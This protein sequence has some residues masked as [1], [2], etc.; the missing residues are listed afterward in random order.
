[1][2]I[3]SSTNPLK[4]LMI[5]DSRGD[6]VLIR[7]S[8]DKAMPNAYVVD[9]A[10]TLS[11]ALNM[12]EGNEYDVALLDR[13]LPD[14]DGFSGLH[15]I[16]NMSPR[17][18]II[19]LTG[20]QDETTAFEAIEQGAQDYLFKDRL[21]GHVIKRSLQFS[22]LRK[23]FEG[24]LL[25]RA[26]FDPLT[27]LANRMLFDSRLDM[28]LARMRRQ[29]TILCVMFI[30]LD[31]FKRVN[32]NHGHLVGDR[33]LQL[34]GER[35]QSALRKT[36]TV[37]RFGGDEF[38]L[39]LESNHDDPDG[40]L[41]ANKIISLFEKPFHV[42]ERVFRVSISIGI[43]TCSYESIKSR[44]ILL[45]EADSAMYAAKHSVGSSYQL[46]RP[47]FNKLLRAS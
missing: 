41:V 42:K 44:E 45:A 35:I 47:D 46:Y 20:H 38:A 24:V 27:G 7:L 6:A 11:Q 33:L 8:L 34:V 19:F 32:D 5:E 15:S 9:H 10:S 4:I 31:D 29:T 14:A 17:L 40:E 39:I 12:L 37:A 21:D 13:S 28:L 22:V 16:Q 30:D 2:K 36:D 26:N 1:M 18:P 23:Q 25:A 3:T 43:T